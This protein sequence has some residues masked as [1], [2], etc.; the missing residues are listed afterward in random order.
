MKFN[1]EHLKTDFYRYVKFIFG[2]GLSLMLNLLVTYILTEVVH[3]WH[4]LSFGIALG[5]E[6]FFLF[7]YHSLFT[8]KKKGRFLVFVIVILFISTLNWILVYIAS[9]TLGIHYLISI[10]GVA[11]LVS[12]LNYG[13]NKKL[14]FR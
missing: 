6:I 7:I 1:Y 10:I 12:L 11:L 3:L 5:L 13:L 4:M 9:I 8:F 2:G 14:V